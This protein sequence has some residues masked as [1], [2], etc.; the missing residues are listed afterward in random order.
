MPYKLEPAQNNKF[1]VVSDKGTYLSNKPLTKKNALNQIYAVS[2]NEGLIGGSSDKFA[3]HAIVFKKPYNP[4][5]VIIDSQPF[6][7]KKGIPFIR[8]TE[9]SYRVRNIPKTKFD[10]DTYRTKVINEDISLIYGELK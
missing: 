5:N 9:H 4:E 7:H 2:I 1:Y 10:K 8:E 3:L 6:L